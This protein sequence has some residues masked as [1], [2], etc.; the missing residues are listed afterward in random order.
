MTVSETAVWKKQTHVDFPTSHLLP[1]FKLIS[2]PDL[3]GVCLYVSAWPWEIWVRVLIMDCDG[4][5]RVFLH[6]FVTDIL[7]YRQD[8]ENAVFGLAARVGEMSASP[9][10]RIPRGKLL[11]IFSFLAYL[12][13]S[14]SSRSIKT[15]ENVQKKKIQE[16][17]LG[18]LDR[19]SSG[20]KYFTCICL[21]SVRSKVV[22]VTHLF[23]A[24]RTIVIIR[25]WHRERSF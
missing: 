5:G 24:H 7:H 2:Y 11:V 6:L 12:T 20:L 3:P 4:T 10:L 18:L 9:P 25:H 8:K 13:T 22:S 23:I 21:L 19:H 15:L 16:S 14:T 17:C 1:G